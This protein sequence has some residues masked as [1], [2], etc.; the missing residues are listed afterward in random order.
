ME[1][2]IH[3]LAERA[4]VTSRTLRHYDRVGLLPPSHVG[5]NGYRYYDLAAVVRLQRIL[6]MRRLG[7]SLPAI[8]EVLSNEVDEQVGLSAHIAALEDERDLIDQRI[9]AARDALEA[10]RAGAEPGPDVLL[11]GFNDRYR[12]EVVARWG[13]DAYRASNTWWHSMSLVQQQ[14]WVRA[15]DGLVSEWIAAWRDGASATSAHAQ[16]LAARHVVWLTD[17]PGTPQPDSEPE[18]TADMVIGL[19]DTYVDEPSF[20]TAFGGAEPATFVRDA[21]HHYARMSM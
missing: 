17:I 3:Q 21:L 5:S 4:G 18:R 11:E 19:G 8:G 6:W 2:M 20:T 14:E 13:E 15:R 10:V 1:W 12:D 7:M 16:A 9:K